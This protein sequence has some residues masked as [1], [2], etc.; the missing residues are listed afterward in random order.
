VVSVI[1]GGASPEEVRSNIGY[2]KEPIP[3]AVWA[4]LKSEGLI[5]PESPTPG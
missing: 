4:E 1:P 5:D 2:L 3:T